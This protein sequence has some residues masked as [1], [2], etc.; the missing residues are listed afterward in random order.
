MKIF[1]TIAVS[2]LMVLGSLYYTNEQVKDLADK[3]ARLTALGA[4]Q[5]ISSL[6][7][8]TP[9]IDVDVLPITDITTNTTKKITWA[10]VKASLKTYQDTL[11]SPTFSTSAGLSALLSDETGSGGGIVRATGP[12]ISGA[13]L[14]GSPTLTTPSFDVAGADATGDIYYNGGSGVFT[15]L[16][17]GS[18]GN[19]L[20]VTAG[21]PAWASASSDFAFG[22]VRST[23]LLSTASSTIYGL[24]VGSTLAATTTNNLL[25][26]NNAST[27]NL[28]ASREIRFSSGSNFSGWAS[29]T[30]YEIIVNANTNNGPTTIGGYV[31]DTATCSAG[32]VVVGGGGKASD[33]E[34]FPLISSSYPTGN[35]SWTVRWQGTSN[36]TNNDVNAYAICVKP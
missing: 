1:A 36:S 30:G 8:Y 15:R 14:T 16:G 26:E 20:T 29:S 10:N 32:K 34:S 33:S 22:F 18:T 2:A 9:A 6:T 3:V 28:T 5:T 12:T 11:Y 21:V 17:I 24:T 25:V 35:S 27:T 4:S 13:Q 23:G 31:S 19:L 7:S